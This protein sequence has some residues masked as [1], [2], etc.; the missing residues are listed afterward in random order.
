MVKY[1]DIPEK[2]P[3]LYIFD[4]N[5][6]KRF[7]IDISD[8]VNNPIIIKWTKFNLYKEHTKFYNYF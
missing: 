2:S 3:N 4:Y 5:E 1:K 7:N 8:Y 6:L